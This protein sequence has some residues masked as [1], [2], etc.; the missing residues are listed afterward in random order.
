MTTAP[1]SSELDEIDVVSDDGPMDLICRGAVV[2]ATDDNGKM[3]DI[4]E[5]EE[6]II[7]DDDERVP[8]LKPMA[9]DLRAELKFSANFHKGML[10]VESIIIPL[11][12]CKAMRVFGNVLDKC[13]HETNERTQLDMINVN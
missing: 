8:P 1:D 10:T 11:L 4:T 12:L 13:P 9:F 2:D 6:D 3:D 5:P 7:V